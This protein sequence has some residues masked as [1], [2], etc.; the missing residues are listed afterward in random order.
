MNE[1]QTAPPA[2]SPPAEPRTVPVFVKTVDGKPLSE[3][4]ARLLA[5]SIEQATRGETTVMGLLLKYARLFAGFGMREFA[6]QCGVLPSKYSDAEDGEYDL[7]A[8]ECE[9]VLNRLE[10]RRKEITSAPPA[11]SHDTAAP[12]TNSVTPST[13]YLE[14]A[15]HV[16]ETK[17]AKS[18]NGPQGVSA[19]QSGGHC[20]RPPVPVADDGTAGMRS[21]AASEKRLHRADECNE[22]ALPPV[23]PRT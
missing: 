4:S 18:G 9:R 3:E 2:P 7:S 14:D 10:A 12:P 16:D 22:Q 17:Q 20:A 8:D 6:K 13:E 19:S 1:K 5:E 21:Q 23:L 11:A 15:I